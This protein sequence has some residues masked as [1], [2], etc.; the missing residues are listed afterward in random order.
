L[1]RYKRAH[2]ERG[3]AEKARAFSHFGRVKAFR[4]MYTDGM[5]T[6]LDA[7]G[8]GA[9]LHPDRLSDRGV[10]ASSVR[11]PEPRLAP[12]DS[13]ALKYEGRMP[14]GM[15]Q[16]L[17]HRQACQSYIPAERVP[18]RASWEERTAA[19]GIT[20][21]MPLVAQRTHLAQARAHGSRHTPARPTLAQLREQE[22][23][24]KQ[25]ISGLAQHVQDLQQY[26]RRANLANTSFPPVRN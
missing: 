8:H 2:P 13:N 18:A 10:A 25:S 6:H 22:R 15:Q 12:A 17:E 21:N 23:T 19:L 14:P 16:V 1:T 5:N 20:R 3:G 7:A 11:T 9:R 26:A 24:L 4:T